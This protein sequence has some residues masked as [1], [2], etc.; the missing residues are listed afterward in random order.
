[1][2]LA[3]GVNTTEWSAAYTASCT[4]K[5]FPATAA[6]SVKGS[7]LC[8]SDSDIKG[9]S[10]LHR[11]GHLYFRYFYWLFS[12]SVMRKRNHSPTQDNDS[13]ATKTLLD[14]KVKHSHKK[15]EDNTESEIQYG[16]ADPDKTMGRT[17]R[18]WDSELLLQ[19]SLL[20][21]SLILLTSVPGGLC[22]IVPSMVCLETWV[23][24]CL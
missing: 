21:I 15:G 4:E 24:P 23:H 13:S 10:I 5:R 17:L 6:S 22:N 19:T 2:S 7:K 18:R 20:N 3:L 14:S 11:C 12:I 9:W 8:R 16:S 1:M